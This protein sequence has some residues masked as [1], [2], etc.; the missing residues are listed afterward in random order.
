MLA[1]LRGEHSIS[2]LCR[3]EALAESLYYSWSKDFLE[4]GKRRLAGDKE[5]QA[6]LADFVKGARLDEVL[7]PNDCGG[8]QLVV[9]TLDPKIVYDSMTRGNC[10]SRAYVIL[11]SHYFGD[12]T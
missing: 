9:K 12:H 8:V 10:I 2:E 11:S 1:G 7:A 5:R 3:R 6:N 4:A